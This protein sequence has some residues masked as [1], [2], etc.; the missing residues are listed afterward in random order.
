MPRADS[1][2]ELGGGA[3]RLDEPGRGG[4]TAEPERLTEFDADGTGVERSR[5]SAEGERDDGSGEE[6]L[7]RACAVTTWTGGDAD[8]CAG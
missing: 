1:V 6:A 8:Q 5:D 4:E 7:V 2:P 3:G